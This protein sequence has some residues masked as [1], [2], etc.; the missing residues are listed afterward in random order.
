MSK[1]IRLTVVKRDGRV[2]AV[3]FDKITSRY[4]PMRTQHSTSLDCVDQ[5]EHSSSRHVTVLTNENTVLQVTL[6]D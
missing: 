4:G 5:S 3:M 2:E 1:S 6:Q